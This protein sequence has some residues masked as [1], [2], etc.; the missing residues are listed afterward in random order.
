VKLQAFAR[1]ARTCGSKPTSPSGARVAAGARALPAAAAAA[2]PDTAGEGR[3]T[4]GDI[5]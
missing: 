2:A 5:N 1:G 3:A 4:T